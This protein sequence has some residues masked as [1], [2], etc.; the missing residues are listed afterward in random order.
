[1]C[2]YI[3]IHYKSCIMI[4]VYIPVKHITIKLELVKQI[5]ALNILNPVLIP[6]PT[7]PDHLCAPVVVSEVLEGLALQAPIPP[8]TPWRS[9]M[10]FK[11]LQTINEN[12]EHLSDVEIL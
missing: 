9:W 3:Y 8:F 11:H 10:L 12:A 4:R 5:Q 1:M 7:R 6:G 2:I